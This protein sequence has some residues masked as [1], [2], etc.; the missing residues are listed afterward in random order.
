MSC[1]AWR[2]GNKGAEVRVE[3]ISDSSSGEK[4]ERLTFARP[5][6]AAFQSHLQKISDPS[7]RGELAGLLEDI[8]Q[9][10]RR[11]LSDRGKEELEVYKGAVRKFMQKALSASYA[12]EEHQARR[13][14]GKFVVYLVT[15]RVDEALETLT[16]L[17]VAGQQDVFRL[18][19]VLEEI[20]GLLMDLYL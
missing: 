3:K 4:P 15:R 14:D 6:G 19:G 8:D 17:L 2:S 11:L 5:I 9:K 12:V 10:G 1:A 20:R 18:A 13:S 7:L 16:G